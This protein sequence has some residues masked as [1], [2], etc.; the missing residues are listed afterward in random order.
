MDIKIEEMPTDPKTIRRYFKLR[1]RFVELTQ[2]PEA[3]YERDDK[4]FYKNKFVAAMWMMFNA[5]YRTAARLLKRQ[6]QNDLHY[7]VIGR[8]DPD[9]HTFADNPRRHAHY[10][11]AIKEQ[12][13]LGDKHPGT[14]FG[15]FALVS[16]YKKDEK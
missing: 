13:R 15:V 3:A 6:G 5:G 1:D 10:D 16:T 12:R 9:G 2:L 7:Y 11:N 14:K 4:L 8:L